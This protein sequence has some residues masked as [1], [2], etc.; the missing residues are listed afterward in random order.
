MLVANTASAARQM[1]N[2]GRGVV[3]VRTGTSSIF[4]SW[5]LLGLDPAGIG[6]NLYRSANGGTYA[7]L[8]SSVL[9]G[10]TCYT[11]TSPNLTVSNA[12]YVKPVIGGVEQAASGS[13]T[14]SANHA[15]EP[16]VRIPLHAVPGSGY[17]TKFVWV[18]DLDG[19][20][21]YD[22]VIDRLAP[23]DPN[24]ND[25]GLGHQFLEAYKRDGTRLWSIDMG[26]SS[27]GTYNIS[28]GAATISM[29]MYDGVTVYDLNGDGKAEVVLKVADGVKF[30]NGTTFTNSDTNKQF[31]AILNGQTGNM[32][33]NIAFPTD[34]YAQSGKYGTQLGIGYLDGTTPSVIGWL[35]NRNADKSFND[36]IVAWH[37][38]GTTL[39]QTWKLPLPST[40][41]NIACFH[42]M[43]IADVDG[44]GK[45]E[46]CPGNFLV[47]SNGTVRYTLSGVVH[48]DRHYMCKMDPNRAGL[49]GYGIQQ[50]NPSGL[51][52]YYYDANTGAFIWKHMFS[53]GDVAR[54][55]VGDVDPNYL[56]F[57]AWSFYGLYNA[58]SNV[59]TCSDTTKQPYPD[60]EFWWDGDLTSEGL[61]DAKF[62]KW[63][64]ANPTPT[65]SCP[66][67]L[68]VTDYGAVYSGHNPMFF[69]DIFG[70][71]RTEVIDFNSD[72]SQMMIF[73][74][75]IPTTYR[76]Y[77]MAHN[78]EYRVNLTTKGYME[79]PQ[80][81]YYMGAGMAT[82]PVPN[83]VYVGGTTQP[84]SA[85]TGLTAT[86]GNAQ[87]SLSW[88]A[89]SGATSYNVKRATVS[90]G[91]YTTVASPTT[92]S[93]A[94]TGLTN[95][96]TYYYVV[97]A[98]NGAG[99]SA[100]SSQV[101]ATPISGGGGTITN[102]TYNLINLASGLAL[103]NKGLTTNGSAVG[104]W[105]KGSSNNLKWVVT[106]QSDGYYKLSC[107][108]GGLYLDGMGSTTNGAPAGQWSGNSS[109]NQEWSIVAAGSYY[110]LVNRTSGL[111]LDSLGGTT[112]GDPVGQSADS[113]SSNQQWSFVA[114]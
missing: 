32:I 10:G 21:E 31:L 84:P 112:N 2:L 90:G 4:V 65:A 48:G 74:T 8:N 30:P 26:P 61:N 46:I 103:D 64:P 12:Y 11:D 102:G 41:A 109:T 24:N 56:G 17:Y 95:G 76:I 37:L 29:G 107:V 36:I 20:G 22:F 87:V 15:T 85:P 16:I 110:K 68:T 18:G 58:R 55:L 91:S 97:S 42:Q 40:T 50:D 14:L 13:F 104:L 38:S 28:P 67:L 79:S 47:N 100:N 35:R 93:Y 94:N 34:F 44:D 72:Y 96:T 23:S 108:T 80:L 83:I 89:S 105:T 43:I 88:T 19:D 49:Q 69:G 106:L 33:A 63:D 59:L 70:D 27:T 82:P 66:R 101:S 5:R 6:F 62:E 9:T 71:W 7:K 75:D 3:A 1:E 77:T 111:R 78:P 52:D 92:T 73:T 60:Q 51:A 98:V 114:P 45:D 53:T 99:E 81:D 54:G 57:E 25:I 39:S 86:A 113:A